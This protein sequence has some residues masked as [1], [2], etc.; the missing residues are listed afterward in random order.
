ERDFGG[1]ESALRPEQ[2][3]ALLALPAAA[4]RLVRRAIELYAHLRLAQRA[5][6]LD[7]GDEFEAVG[8]LLEI[9]PADRPGARDLVETNTEIVAP[10]LIDAELVERL[11]HIE[12]ALAHRNDADFRL[13]ATR[14]DVLVE[15][16]RAHEGEHGVAFIVMQARLLAEDGIAQADVE[17][18]FRHEI[19]GNDDVDP[20]QTAVDDG[21]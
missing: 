10:D 1:I 9:L 19:L 8:E 3:I 2:P 18:A 6:F 20:L 11:A 16:V 17:P 4:G 12:I 14:G 13:P 15:L 21:V 7:H 5:F